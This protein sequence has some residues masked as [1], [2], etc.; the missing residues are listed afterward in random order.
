MAQGMPEQ[1]KYGVKMRSDDEM[2]LHEVM[3]KN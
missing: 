3:Y 2:C 1:I